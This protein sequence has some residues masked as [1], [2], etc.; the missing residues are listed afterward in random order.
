[1]HL[2]RLFSDIYLDTAK[3][4]QLARRKETKRD[5]VNIRQTGRQI[6]S[7]DH[8]HTLARAHTQIWR[9]TEGIVYRQPGKMP[10]YINTLLVCG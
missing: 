4:R 9:Q 3:D 2:V 5:K 6:N 8:I 10:R 1:M 7:E